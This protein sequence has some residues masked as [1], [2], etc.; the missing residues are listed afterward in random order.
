VYSGV[1]PDNESMYRALR[2]NFG[3]WEAR[4]G[5]VERLGDVHETVS[6]PGEPVVYF[7]AVGCTP[8]WAEEVLKSAAVI[9]RIP[10]PVRVAGIIARG[11]TPAC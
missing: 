1:K 3:D 5:V 4:W 6:L 10:E 7:E 8:Q 2:S 9:S 11:L